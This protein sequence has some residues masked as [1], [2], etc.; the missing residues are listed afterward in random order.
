MKP[1]D[2][3]EDDDFGLTTAEKRHNKRKLDLEQ[4][5][6]SLS[7]LANSTFRERMDEFNTGLSKL[8]EH[9][10]LPRISAAGNGQ[11]S[12][13]AISPYYI[14]FPFPLNSREGKNV[15][16]GLC[17]NSYYC[18]FCISVSKWNGREYQ[19]NERRSLKDVVYKAFMN[20]ID[21]NCPMQ[22]M[23]QLLYNTVNLFDR[24]GMNDVIERRAHQ[25]GVTVRSNENRNRLSILK[26]YD[27]KHFT[28]ISD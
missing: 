3:S 6:G 8:T 23:F 19:T 26:K 13:C 22:Q 11:V 21:R 9:N 18:T 7:K 12:I 14:Y 5:T 28:K 10:D 25:G 20:H 4:K 24:E 16:I 1:K 27:F 15:P 2:D 17:W